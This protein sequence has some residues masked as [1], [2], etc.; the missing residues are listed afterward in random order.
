MRRGYTRPVRLR[1]SLAL[2]AIALA[3]APAP[4]ASA[5]RGRAVRVPRTL[6]AVTTNARF[7]SLHEDDRGLCFGTVAPGDTGA[8]LTADG[9]HLGETVITEAIANTNRCGGVENYSIRIDRGRL[10]GRYFDYGATLVVGARIEPAG[11]IVP[12][13]GAAPG[14][15]PLATVMY[16]ADTDGDGQA[17]LLS[18][19]YPCDSAQRP[20]R[21]NYPTHMCS[22]Y[23]IAV[24]DHWQRARVDQQAI[25]NR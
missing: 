17:D 25:C 2:A 6:A 24:R 20:T 15:N 22:E 4:P 21:V 23:W 16:A 13:V 9:E 1:S 10:G 8:V 11:K 14:D 18:D 12:G 7:C 19:Q 5:R 3:S